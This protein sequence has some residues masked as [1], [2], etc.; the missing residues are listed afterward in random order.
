MEANLGAVCAA[1][2]RVHMSLLANPSHLEAVDPVVLGKVLSSFESLHLRVLP[3]VNAE[4]GYL[5]CIMESQWKLLLS[6]T[7]EY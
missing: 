4:T 7:K 6:L 2:K 1:G 3:C 5:S